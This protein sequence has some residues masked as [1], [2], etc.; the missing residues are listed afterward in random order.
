MISRAAG[1]R[2]VSP[3]K[4]LLMTA[5]SDWFAA[6]GLQF[7]CSKCGNCC[8]GEPG[9]VQ[10]T[11]AE[12][13]R[14]AARLGLDVATFYERHTREQDGAILLRE[15]PSREGLDCALLERDANGKGV[16]TVYAD[17]PTQ[18]KTWPFWPE[19]LASRSQWEQAKSSTPCAGMDNGQHHDAEE[20]RAIAAQDATATRL[21]QQEAVER[22]WSERRVKARTD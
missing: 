17:R 1:L 7:T 15:K 13:E 4:R 19:N 9:F 10:F 5:P 22:I 20:I 6:D 18:C 3:V 14:M 21:L 2:L 11:S 8:S 12:G 16:C